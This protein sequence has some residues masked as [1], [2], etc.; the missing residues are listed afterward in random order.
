MIATIATG[1][2]AVFYNFMYLTAALQGGAFMPWLA[3][4]LLTSGQAKALVFFGPVL[5]LRWGYM[6]IVTVLL[7]F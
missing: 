5:V 1:I 3:A 4:C 7:I 6:A 2:R